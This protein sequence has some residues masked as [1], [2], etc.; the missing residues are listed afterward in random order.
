MIAPD[1]LPLT[2]IGGYLGAGKTTLINRLLG[3]DH[4]LRVLVLVNDFGAINI[5]AKLLVSAS[6]DTIELANGCVCCTLGADLFVAI[7]QALDRR[8]RPDHLIVE[9][10]GIADPAKIA[11]VAKAEPEL[12]YAPIVTVVDG[13]HGPTLIDDPQIGPQIKGQIACADWLAVSKT[14]AIPGGLRTLNPAA[15]ITTTAA[16]SLEHMALVNPRQPEFSGPATHPRYT[17]WHLVTPRTYDGAQ[18]K[19]ALQNRPPGLFRVKGWVR[20]RDGQGWQVQVVGEAVELQ[21]IPQ[22]A[23]SE[24]VGLGLASRLSPQDCDTWWRELMGKGD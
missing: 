15:A 16:L 22:P 12:A 4:G 18:L 6:D 3:S 20:G 17:K 8:P 23:Q 10:S 13:L 14:D 11:Q 19:A 9:A 21:P 1:P 24:V 5:D 2:V 7:G